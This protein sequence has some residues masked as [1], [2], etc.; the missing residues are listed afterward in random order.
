MV[1][2]PLQSIGVESGPHQDPPARG[3]DKIALGFAFLERMLTGLAD[4][5]DH[6]HHQQNCA[7][8]QEAQADRPLHEHAWIAVGDQPGATQIFFDHRSKDEAE[9]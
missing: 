5:R 6:Q 7:Q 1:K 2:S 3:T 4:R 9:Q 8:D